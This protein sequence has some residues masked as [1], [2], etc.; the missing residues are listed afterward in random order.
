MSFKVLIQKSCSWSS[1]CDKPI[2]LEAAWNCKERSC[3]CQRDVPIVSILHGCG[4]NGRNS[5][6]GRE[7][8]T[9]F[10]ETPLRNPATLRVTSIQSTCFRGESNDCRPLG[11]PFAASPSTFVLPPPGT[12]RLCVG[13]SPPQRP[14]FHA[15]LFHLPISLLTSCRV[16]N[17]LCC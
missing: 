12:R 7:S 1:S 17:S 8:S 13:R 2:C 9:T 11:P 3:R 16:F 14:N 4:A 15:F 5:Q 10:A 6:M